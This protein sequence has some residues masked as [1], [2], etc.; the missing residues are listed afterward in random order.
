MI[1]EMYF[2]IDVDRA[3]HERKIYSIIDWLGGIGGI[4][5]ILMDSVVFILGSWMSFNKGMEFM[6][7]L[8]FG[9]ED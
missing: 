2:R 6:H 7:S 9:D 3:I 4:R 1:A 5:D 8:Y